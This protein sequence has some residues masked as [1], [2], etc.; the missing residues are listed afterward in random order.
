MLKEKSSLP[1]T[2]DR[3]DFSWIIEYMIINYKSEQ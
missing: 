1:R 3:G 2:S